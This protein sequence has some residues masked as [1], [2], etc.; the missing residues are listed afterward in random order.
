MKDA[1]KTKAQ[2]M[3]ELEELRQRI[4]ESERLDTELKRTEERL[5]KISD[6]FLNFGSVPPE[7]IN[8][9]TAL[10]GEL[11]GATCALYNRLDR[12]L[13]Y[14]WGQ[15]NVP[16]DYNPVDKPDGHICYDVIKKAGEKVLVVSNLPETHYAQTDPNVIPYKLQTYIGRAVKFGNAYVGSL[17]VVYQDDFVP[18]EGDKRLMGIIASAIGVEEKRKQAEDELRQSEERY[19]LATSAGQ[20]GV[21]D[22]NLET[23]EIYVDPNLK[24]IL[25]YADHEIRNH[26]DDWGK[27][28][29]LDDVEQVMT[30]AKAHLE[31]LKPQYEV[32]HRMLHKDGGIRWFL[33]RGTAIRDTN[34]KPY[35]MLGADT[36]I[37]ESKQAE[38]ALREREAELKVRSRDLEEL[39]AALKVLLRRREEDKTELAES[40]QVNVKELVLPYL[41]KLKKSR[42]Q[43]H[44]VTLIRI[45]E[46]HL[47]DIVSPFTTKLS[48]RFL[49]LTPT[50]IKLAN[51]I[52][53]GRTTKEA[54]E[55][56]GLSENTIQVHR[57]HIR[58]KLGLKHKKINLMSYLRSLD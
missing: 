7:N 27:L 34:G 54:A 2:L 35:R 10:C 4:A 26:L 21:W 41:E 14:S 24:A 37:T 12:G 32:A 33:A 57:H 16:P 19:E 50:E 49:K 52:K 30:E 38:Q 44:Q 15:W 53:D 29:H 3:S 46:S 6:C 17:C 55:L 31:G 40:V 5:V 43:P 51:L 18:S 23:N 39:N 48:S 36:D 47:K 1:G 22:W 42:L 11:L 45:L 20:V 8:R 9:L 28:V 25:G 58:S 56:L 13:L